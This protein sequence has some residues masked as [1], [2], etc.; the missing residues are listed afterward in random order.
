MIN[1]IKIDPFKI[2][3]ECAINELIRRVYDEFVAPDYSIDGNECFYDWILPGK[4]ADRQKNCVNLFVATVDSQIVGMVETRDDKYV[5]LLFVDKLYHRMGIAKALFKTALE[6]CLSRDSTFKKFYVHASPYSINV[7][8][9][10]GFK[11]TGGIRVENGIKYLP[12]EMD[13]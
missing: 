3:Q 11:D 2:R 4:I 5:S 9:R 10:L 8:V 7:Y 6:N 13:L 1:A 12:M